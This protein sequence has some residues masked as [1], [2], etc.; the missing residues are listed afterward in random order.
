[1]R[2]N[3]GRT[4]RSPP[5]VGPSAV[6]DRIALG[7]AGLG[8]GLGRGPTSDVYRLAPP[9][10]QLV[11]E[12][13]VASE[14]RSPAGR[15]RRPISGA[16]DGRREPTLGR[17]PHPRGIVEAR[18]RNLRAD[19]FPAD[20]PPTDATLSEL[21]HL[22][23][24]SPRLNHRCRRLRGARNAGGPSFRTRRGFGEGHG[25]CSFR[26]STWSTSR[27]LDTS[28]HDFQVVRSPAHRSG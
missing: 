10:L 1:M 27:H 18:V 5:F 16:R 7:V 15:C 21:T 26:R 12:L 22:P 2:N 13:A 23:L 8:I 17:A 25:V 6:L 11:P 14:R 4:R 19:G 28:R 3:V 20:G 9:R 24:E